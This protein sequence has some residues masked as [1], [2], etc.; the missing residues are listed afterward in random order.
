MGLDDPPTSGITGPIAYPAAGDIAPNLMSE[1]GVEDRPSIETPRPSTGTT[2]MD[3]PT[4]TQSDTNSRHEEGH[5][6]DHRGHG[7]DE[8]GLRFPP[9]LRTMT[10][11]SGKPYSSFSKGMKWFIVTLAGIAAVFSPIRYVRHLL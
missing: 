7:L 11:V 8:D 3:D 10:S 5:D 9:A 1:S 2:L 4:A 6:H